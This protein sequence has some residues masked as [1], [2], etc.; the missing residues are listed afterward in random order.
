MTSREGGVRRRLPATGLVLALALA[1]CGGWAGQQPAASPQVASSVVE[2]HQ[3]SNLPQ[4]TGSTEPTE[5]AS[6]PTVHRS[7][8]IGERIGSMSLREKVRQLLVVGFSGTSA[9]T[10]LIR[11]RRPG[12]LIY[13]DGNLSSR[14]Q[15][16][17]MSQRA[18]Q[19]SRRV[20]QPL[21]TMTDQEG[22]AVTRIPGMEDV[23]A[24]ADFAG[25]ARWTRRTAH[26]TA[27]VLRRSG[28][29]VDLAP[30]VDVNTAGAGGVIGDR[31][32]SADPKVASRLVQAQVCG[33][34]AGG[35]AATAKHFPGHGS[36]ATDSH[37]STATIS[38]SPSTWRRLDRPPFDAA[39]RSHVDLV[40]VGHLAFPAMD[41][42]GRPATISGQLIRG[43]LR[44]RLGF[45][46][47]VISDALNM[48]GIT[49]W[50]SAGQ[51][52][53]RAIGAGVDMLLMPP[54]A[55]EAVRGI[56][57]AVRDGR[58]TEA[59]IDRSVERVLSLKQRL[60]L[61]AADAS[62]PSC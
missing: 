45:D 56:L 58:L 43:L 23:P 36:T 20:S 29:N 53:V 4:P 27:D 28:I 22:G 33:Y 32:F 25:N 16:R 11:N 38:E 5:R 48:G 62:L 12:G 55:P 6:S 19:L 30:V 8:P 59:R 44:Q 49:S 1:S 26:S 50:G 7:D 2:Q 52:S 57:D 51:I 24:G 10:T 35:V 46:G 40:M 34:H 15:I 37:L 31:S 39:V 3:Q 17:T 60:G 47:V 9:P 21:L 41:A 13:F 61:Y 54:D 18:Q 14:D 42:T